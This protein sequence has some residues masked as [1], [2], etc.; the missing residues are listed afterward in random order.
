[1]PV[2]KKVYAVNV[3]DTGKNFNFKRLS[4]TLLDKS[5][6]LTLIHYTGDHTTAT[7]FPHGNSKPKGS[8]Q[9]VRSCPSVLQKANEIQDV[10]SNV[11][12]KMVAEVDCANFHQPVL[13]PRDTTQI[14]NLQ[15]R[16]RQKFRLTHDSLYNLHELAYDL[17]G[18]VSKITTYPNLI[19][20]CGL[21]GIKEELDRLILTAPDD[22]VL[23]SYDTT[24][25]LGD[26]Y[27]SPFLFKHVLFKSNP[28]V[29]AAFLLHERKFKYVHKEL[30]LQL[31][32]EIPSL[33]T[34]SSPVPI[35][36][37]D[38]T[39]LNTAIDETLTGVHRVRCWNHT[40]NA[41]K[42]WLRR[43]GAVSDEIPVYVSNLRDLF[44]QP[45]EEAYEN[46]L[47]ELK[48]KWS[49]TF[50]EYYYNSIHPEVSIPDMMLHIMCM[51]TSAK[52]CIILHI[53]LG[54]S[55]HCYNFTH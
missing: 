55:K 15:A 23:M 34:I 39:A 44:H 25:Q 6:S 28:V 54:N 42:L 4:Y 2:V 29:P 8:K 7:Q 27:L 9:Y 22:S 31:K 14:R 35:V 18:F 30:M 1:M 48:M 46:K 36:V 53:I 51:I 19:V 20:V 32:E 41:V 49:D 13:L 12:K 24:F 52:P 21:K 45:S 10:P 11:Y 43:H 37:D 47:S 3:D 17:D 40:I 26:F 38:E 5:S 50:S 16:N 33:A